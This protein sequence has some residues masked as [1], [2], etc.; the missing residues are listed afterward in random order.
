MNKGKPAILVNYKDDNVRCVYDANEKVFV[1]YPNTKAEVTFFSVSNAD[2]KR[3][4][5]KLKFFTNGSFNKKGFAFLLSGLNSSEWKPET[6]KSKMIAE[7]LLDLSGKLTISGIK[8][9]KTKLAEK[10][11]SIEGGDL[12]LN[13]E[14]KETKL[15]KFIL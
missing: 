11:T 13:E 6:I 15:V 14:G 12:A 5:R 9:I 7:G 1:D 10:L 8:F 4:L 3:N 2:I